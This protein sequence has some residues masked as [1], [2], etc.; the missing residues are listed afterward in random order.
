MEVY[1]IMQRIKVA[2]IKC[3]L[4]SEFDGSVKGDLSVDDPSDEDGLK[5]IE[6]L[7]K[8]NDTEQHDKHNKENS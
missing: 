7:L 2:K 3:K 6:K 5:I 4:N 8:E 1:R